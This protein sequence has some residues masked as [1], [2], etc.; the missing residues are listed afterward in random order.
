MASKRLFKKNM[1]SSKFKIINLFLNMLKKKYFFSSIKKIYKRFEKDTSIEAK[2]WA[3]LNSKKTTEEFCRSIDSLLFDEVKFDVNLIEKEAI[4][5]IASLN[6]SFGGPGVAGPGNYMFLYFLIRKF[7]LCNIVETG[8]AAGWTSLSILRA[9]KKNGKG[10]LYS[11]DFPYLRLA[12]PEKYIGFLADN[13]S[14]KYNWVLDV[15]GDDLALHEIKNHLGDESIDL[16]HYDS[17]KSYSGRVNALKSLNSK[18]SSKTI[19]LFDD[20]H[21]NL[22]FKDFVQKNNK[23]FLVLEFNGKFTGVCGMNHLIQL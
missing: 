1:I 3:K 22:H 16:F 10:N 21:N 4:E 18:L 5:K 23:D 7:K 17:D 14:N 8:V 9:L 13:E 11:S 20:I 6:F 19:I 2:K 15:R 12:D